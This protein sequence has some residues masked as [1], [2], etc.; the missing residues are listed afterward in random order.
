MTR[1]TLLI[2]KY[3]FLLPFAFLL[4]G[5][6]GKV[7]EIK[8]DREIATEVI[9]VTDGDSIGIRHRIRCTVGSKIKYTTGVKYIGI[10]ALERHA[11]FYKSARE[12]NKSLVFGKTVRLVFDREKVDGNGRLL[13]YVY[14]GDIFVNAEMVRRGYARASSAEPNTK[15]DALFQQLEQEARENNRG[16]WSLRGL[17]QETEPEPVDHQDAAVTR[18][19]CGYAASRNSKIFH[20]LSCR[21]VKSIA[22]ENKV[23][24]RTLKEALESDRRPCKVC[25]PEEFENI[26][27]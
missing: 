18:D 21:S 19:D 3:S 9:R 8:T 13:A 12:L 25:K 2:L 6:S 10:D 27:E 5:C 17:V 26:S 7:M 11:P 14:A 24:F 20:L 15:H 16:M 4:V 1:V 23:Y 22:E